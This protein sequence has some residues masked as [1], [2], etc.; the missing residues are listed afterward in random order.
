MLFQVPAIFLVSFFAESEELSPS[1]K[2][3]FQPS[4]SIFI[5]MFDLYPAFSYFY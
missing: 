5:I 1:P 3:A 4:G 2:S